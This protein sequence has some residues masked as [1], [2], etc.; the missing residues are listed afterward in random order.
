M[1][2][3]TLSEVAR[4]ASTSVMAASVV[5]NGARSNT[6]VSDEVRVRVRTSA[7]RLG[8]QPSTLARSLRK[9]KTDLIGFYGGYGFHQLKMPFA[10]E[11]LSGLQRACEERHKDLVLYG[12]FRERDTGGL[13]RQLVGGTIDALVLLAPEN[14]PL[15]ERLKQSALPVIAVVDP[16]DGLA[17]LG[18][19]D[20]EGGRLAARHLEASGCK[21]LAFRRAPEPR[22]SQRR[23]EEGFCMEAQKLKLPVEIL[24]E[25]HWSGTLDEASQWRLFDPAHRPD[26]VFCANDL[27][28][29]HQLGDAQKLGISVPDDMKVVG[30][31]GIVGVIPSARTLTTIHAPWALA[32]ERAVYAL[33]DHAP[34]RETLLPVSLI[35]GDTT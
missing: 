4:E 26:G 28:A 32:A 15:A 5:L 21:R 29:H 17:S 35:P 6:R 13:F 34:P 16:I 23:R 1:K 31:D 10:S 7:E 3:V 12:S 30:F 8:Y 11:L 14:D 9:Q 18:V 27:I 33:L 22:R 2:R 19:D 25:N 24:Q 20:A